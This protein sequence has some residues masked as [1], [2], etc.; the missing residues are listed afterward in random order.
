M[1]KAFLLLAGMAAGMNMYAQ[2][3][4]V[5]MRINNKDITRSEFEYSYNKN[6]NEQT[7]DQKTLDEYVQLFIDFKLKVAEAES[8]KMDTL[9]SFRNEFKGYRDQQAQDYLIDE[10]FIEEECRKVYEQTKNNIGPEGLVRTAHILLFIPQGAEV[11]QQEQIKARMDSIYTVLQNGGDFAE[12]ATKFSQDASARQGG[13]LPWI[14]AK[15]VYPE[16]AQVAYSLQVGELSKPFL[17]P[18]GV[19][20]MKLLDKKQF[21][22]YEFHQKD[23]RAFLERRGVRQESMKAKA[24]KLYKQYGGTI[25]REDVLAHEDS[26]LESRHPEFRY[27]MQEYY[28]GLLL[29]EVSN[30]MVWEKASKD[31]EGLERYFKK[32]KKKYV[33]DAP[34]FKGAVVH[35][36]TPE[37]AAR[38]KKEMKKMPED[39]WRKYILRD[40]NQDS[41]KLAYMEKGL[42]KIGDNAN[43][44]YLVFGQ[45]KSQP[46]EKY[47]YAV[48]VGKVQKKR[49][50]S[51]RDVR[52][53]L[54]ADYQ[55][56]LEEAWIKEIREKYK[57]KV[58]VFDD[59]V[60]TVNNH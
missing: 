39:Q 32:N 44:D 7:L 3:D 24:E 8:L 20:V 53:L 12:L 38:V 25:A 40:I 48:Q 15:Q 23:I 9:T 41:L 57:D 52:G 16:Y 2:Q 46:K 21:E 18:A 11:A 49:P 51:F 43:V 34:R 22:P 5:I 14:Y 50:E 30:L 60:R 45:G 55:K 54:T 29:F 58:E 47:P 19:H 33:W 42:F 59:V 28:D 56:A 35:C 6:N 17:T 36:A 13:E 1:K 26:L 4:P 27:L 37:L 10:E 31:E